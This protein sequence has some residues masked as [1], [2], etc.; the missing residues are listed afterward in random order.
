MA[1]RE[2]RR[3]KTS[4]PSSESHRLL[5]FKLNKILE[6]EKLFDPAEGLV[7]LHV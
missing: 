2:R 3:V 1:T 7:T 4:A 5:L 6:S